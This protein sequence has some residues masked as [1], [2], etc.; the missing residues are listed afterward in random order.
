MNILSE[1]HKIVKE[2]YPEIKEKITP[3][4]KFKDV[5]IDSL[6]LVMIVLKLE[7]EHHVK[8]DDNKLLDLQTK[9]VQDL[10]NEIERLESSENKKK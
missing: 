8:I 5:K 7:E 9:T 4:T 6:G 2:D 1:I 3:K 10:I